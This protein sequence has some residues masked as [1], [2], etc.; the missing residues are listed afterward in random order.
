MLD[1]KQCFLVGTPYLNSQTSDLSGLE[2]DVQPWSPQNL[3]EA[4]SKVYCSMEKN[5]QD[6]K[7]KNLS[8]LYINYRFLLGHHCVMDELIFSITPTQVENE[9]DFSIVGVFGRAWRLSPT[10]EKLTILTV[11][12]KHLEL[13]EQLNNEDVKYEDIYLMK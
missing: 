11:I 2:E 10:I 7:F 4:L 13:Y 8:Q 6:E 5:E 9:R 12:N 1:L 3:L